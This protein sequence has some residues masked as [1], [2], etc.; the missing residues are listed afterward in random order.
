MNEPSSS[1]RLRGRR[2]LRNHYD[3]ASDYSTTLKPKERTIVSPRRNLWLM[4]QMLSVSSVIPLL[5]YVRYQFKQSSSPLTIIL[6]TMTTPQATISVHPLLQFLENSTNPATYPWPGDIIELKH[7]DFTSFQLSHFQD[8]YFV[9]LFD[10]WSSLNVTTAAA[11][12]ELVGQ[13]LE[14]YAMD[15]KWCDYNM[16]YERTAP[17][18]RPKVRGQLA[19]VIVAYQD[20]QQLTELI[21]ALYLPEHVYCIIHLDRHVS[22]EF[23]QQVQQLAETY[24]PY[25]HVLQFGTILYQTDTV[26]RINLQILRWM[27]IE[28]EL[29]YDFVVLLDGAAM[30]LVSATELLE[31]LL[32]RPATQ[33]ASSAT[34]EHVSPYQ[35][36]WLGAMTHRGK[37]VQSDQTGFLKRRR[38]LLTS[39]SPPYHVRLPRAWAAHVEIPEFIEE[40]MQHKTH[41]GNVGIYSHHVIHKL[42]HSAKVRELLAYSKYSCCCCVEERNWIAAL[43]LIGYQEQALQV[44]GNMFQLWGGETTCQGSMK[45]AVLERNESICYR[46]EDPYFQTTSQQPHYIQGDELWDELVLARQRGYLFARKFSS[47][48]VASV[49]LMNE[50][51]EYLW[52]SD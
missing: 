52:D 8:A 2:S 10:S 50:I 48:S 24:A 3:N 36:V 22:A 32:E 45:N 41:S 14:M 11:K 5:F 40:A 42:L 26:T 7:C 47:D 39:N 13:I 27:T 28:W 16:Q 17:T 34:T 4:L 18:T 6:P 21:D 43:T 31:R 20:I 37:T 23:Q 44:P 51:K 9:P 38:V 29:P 15:Q 49:Q 25:V 46:M 30:P 33:D 35:Q 19:V 12:E 1:Q